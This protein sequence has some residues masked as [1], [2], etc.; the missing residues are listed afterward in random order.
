M[1]NKKKYLLLSIVY[2]SMQS[3]CPLILSSLKGASEDI[4]IEIDTPVAQP[5]TVAPAPSVNNPATQVISVAPALP[6]T[7]PTPTVTVPAVQI[8]PVVKAP[9]PKPISLSEWRKKMLITRSKLAATA[10]KKPLTYASKG[11]TK[12]ME[13]RRVAGRGVPKAAATK[14]PTAPIQ[15]QITPKKKPVK[16]STPPIKPA[17]QKV[18]LSTAPQSQTLSPIS[19]APVAVT[20]PAAAPSAVA[21]PTPVQATI[22]AVIQ[23]PVAATTPQEQPKQEIKL[24]PVQAAAQVV[25]QQP[26]AATTPTEPEITLE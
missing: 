21:Q 26:A 24:E 19:T 9:A 14:Q 10:K 23:Q 18:I 3:V 1:K 7:Q 4:E 11:K 13:E 20:A 5:V 17:T 6:A 22:P 25:T 8:K 12:F 2:L 15:K 16:K